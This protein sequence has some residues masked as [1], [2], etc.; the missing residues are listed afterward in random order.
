M[1]THTIDHI[2]VHSVLQ[3][4][5]LMKRAID[6][7]SSGGMEKLLIREAKAEACSSNFSKLADW[8]M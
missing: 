8:E 4:F 6:H 5:E 2:F 7:H 3:H 1:S